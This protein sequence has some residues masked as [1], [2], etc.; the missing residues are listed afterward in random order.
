MILQNAE[1]K[2]KQIYFDNP[3]IKDN[4]AILEELE[5]L[6]DAIEQD[7]TPKVTLQQGANAL[8]VA[9]QIMDIINSE[10]ERLKKI[11]F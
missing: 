10:Y 4:N 6:A 3:K 1:G 2:R 9:N 5:S 7:S 11:N 8:K